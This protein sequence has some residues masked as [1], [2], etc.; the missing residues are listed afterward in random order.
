MIK[1]RLIRIIFCLI[2][3][4]LISN[5]AVAASNK[6]PGNLAIHISKL[7]YKHPTRLIQYYLE[8]WHLKGPLTEKVA[9][10]ALEKRFT[11]SH[12]CNSGNQASAVLFLEPHIFYNPQ[13]HVFHSEII[14]KVFLNSSPLP[15]LQSPIISFKK[16]AQQNGELSVKPEL[17]IEKA[18]AKAMDKII[19][20]LETDKVFLDALNQPTQTTADAKVLCTALDS[21]PVA[22]FFY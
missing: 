14:A 13:L 5:A 11:N 12:L 17:H 19:K 1:N 8:V 2:A 21:L 22:K 15:D 7:H 16:Q 20:Q 18:Y 4:S 3:G 10:S 9:L 6:L